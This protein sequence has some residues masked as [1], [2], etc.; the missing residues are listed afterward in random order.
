MLISMGSSGYCGGNWRY[1]DQQ[2]RIT[3]SANKTRIIR[4]LFGGFGV[5]HQATFIVLIMPED[6]IRK[7]EDYNPQAKVNGIGGID[8]SQNQKRK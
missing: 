2:G 1:D 4:N 6:L 7:G 3:I 8:N 5:R